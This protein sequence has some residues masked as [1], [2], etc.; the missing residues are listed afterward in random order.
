MRLIDVV[1]NFRRR[2]QRIRTLSR[3]MPL[4]DAARLVLQ[5]NKPGK[6]RIYLRPIGRKITLRRKTTDLACLEK[7]F[8]VG[9]YDSPFQISPGVIID[10]GANI[11]M[12][13]LYFAQRYSDALIVAI[14]PEALNFEILRQNCENLRNVVL[15]KAALW[16]KRCNLT[17]ANPTA[18][19]WM[20]RVADQLRGRENSTLVRSITM[21]DLL[22]KM[23]IN[24]VDLLKL[25]IEGSE[26]E[27]FSEQCREWLNKIHVIV[28]ELHDRYMPGCAQAFYTALTSHKFVQE[29]RGENIFV[30]LSPNE[31]VAGGPAALVGAAIIDPEF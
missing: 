18:E 23:N 14:E 29:I 1:R 16:P 27:L 28:I 10:A 9:E 13:T 24:R 25:D 7:V 30:E 17:I 26:L 22:C 4:H 20:F 15:L 5:Q 3:V 8:I 12:A 19:S 6:V 11:G 2:L 21:H 31:P